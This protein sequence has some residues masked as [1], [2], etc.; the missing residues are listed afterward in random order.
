VLLGRHGTEESKREYERVIA[1]WMALGRRLQVGSAAAITVAELMARFLPWAEE[2]Y[3]LPDGRPSTELGEYKLALRPVNFL[4][5][6]HSA[7]DFGPL[8]LKARTAAAAPS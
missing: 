7:K 8:A 1:E 2:Y 5:G 6:K 3:R 4:Y